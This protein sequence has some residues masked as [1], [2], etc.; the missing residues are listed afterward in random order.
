M[1]Y[2]NLVDVLTPMR[3]GAS[4]KELADLFEI[5]VKRR[6]PYFDSAKQSLNS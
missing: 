5:A 1:V 2:D 3:K 4:N 6:K